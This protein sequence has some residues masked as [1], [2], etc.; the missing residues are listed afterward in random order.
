[1]LARTLR[2]K[3]SAISRSSHLILSFAAAGKTYSR[4]MGTLSKD[5]GL[6]PPWTRGYQTNTRWSSTLG[7]LCSHLGCEGHVTNVST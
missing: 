1:M 5:S 7:H 3:R 2:L 4:P 6:F